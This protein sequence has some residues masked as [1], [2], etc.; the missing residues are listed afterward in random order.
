MKAKRL[1]GQ[2][3]EVRPRKKPIPEPVEEKE[4]APA[5]GRRVEEEYE[6]E[7]EIAPPP[8]RRRV[9]A[10]PKPRRRRPP[11]PEP[12]EELSDL[13][14][15]LLEEDEYEPLPAPPRKKAGRKPKPTTRL[16]IQQIPQGS[17]GFTLEEMGSMDVTLD[18]L[19]EQMWNDP[20]YSQYFA[21]E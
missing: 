18:T 14:E 1:E 21:Q 7:E 6:I 16:R 15:E 12:E 13:E 2:L 20:Q 3:Q 10:P 11:T 4:L 8:P 9:K 5:R 19:T 17:K